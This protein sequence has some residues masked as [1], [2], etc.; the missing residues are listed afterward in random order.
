MQMVSRWYAL[1][2]VFS[3]IFLLSFRTLL[4]KQN[5]QLSV[6]FNYK[7]NDA[8]FE[9]FVTRG[10]LYFKYNLSWV[11]CDNTYTFFFDLR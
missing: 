2:R 9:D 11:N 10:L 1:S 8:T 7:N 3:S 5:T 6:F 4:H